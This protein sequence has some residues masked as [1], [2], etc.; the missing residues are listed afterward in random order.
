[1]RE[2]I[3]QQLK[4][5]HTHIYF[6]LDKLSSNS[7]IINIMQSQWRREGG[8]RWCGR[9]GW[10]PA[11]VNICIIPLSLKLALTRSTLSVQNSL[12]VVWRPGSAQ[13]R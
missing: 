3:L 10:P 7:D 8:A 6:Y 5:Y 2:R 1:M 9:T 12:N 13:T 11:G 4:N